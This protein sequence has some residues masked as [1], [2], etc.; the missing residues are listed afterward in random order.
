MTSFVIGRIVDP[1]LREL[2]VKGQT[3]TI[4]SLGILSGRTCSSFD[5]FDDAKIF[6][7]LTTFKDG[8]MVLAVVGTG[9]DNNGRLRTYLNRIGECPE[10]L[11]EQ[12]N[13]L[14]S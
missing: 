11:R 10:G 13:G 6:D 1:E 4:I 8:D 7:H 3:R 12:L 14:V 9:V 5:V 2:K